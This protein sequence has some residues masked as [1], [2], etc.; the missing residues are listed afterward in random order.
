MQVPTS[1]A[2]EWV[3]EVE[4]ADCYKGWPVK[5]GAAA[6]VWI[7]RKGRPVFA[8]P[9]MTFATQADAETYLDAYREE[10]TRRCRS[11]EFRRLRIACWTRDRQP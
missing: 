2:A 7:S 11:A 3:I 9:P 5:D 4:H 1:S 8:S 10:F 6:E